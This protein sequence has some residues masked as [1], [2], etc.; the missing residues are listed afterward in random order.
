MGARRDSWPAGEAPLLD[1]K[2]QLRQKTWPH[3]QRKRQVLPSPAARTC[4][5]DAI[6]A[7]GPPAARQGPPDS[8][9][10]TQ[11]HLSYWASFILRICHSAVVIAVGAAI[12]VRLPTVWRL[13]MTG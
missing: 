8:R 7:P 1:Q 3:H 4:T 9:S 2:S 11:R 10:V 12:A 13:T 6:A 5:P